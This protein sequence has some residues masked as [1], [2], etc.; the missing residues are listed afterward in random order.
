MGRIVAQLPIWHAI[1]RQLRNPSGLD[2]RL[3]SAAMGIANAQPNRVAIKALRIEPQDTVLE[4]GFGPGYAIK[5]MARE[6]FDGH[7]YGVDQSALMPE[8]AGR[9]NRAAIREGR[10]ALHQARFDCL[11][12]DDACIDK[13]LAVNVIYFWDD[14]P[15]MA[16][17]IRRVL[18]PGG[19]AAVYATDSGKMSRW[20]FAGA[21]THRLYGAQSLP[22]ALANAGFDLHHVFVRKVHIIGSIRGVLTTFRYGDKVSALPS[23]AIARARPAH[24]VYPRPRPPG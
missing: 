21:P 13:L 5:A 2:G 23:N 12:C 16:R 11:P 18:R 4:L 14:L 24:A 17:E 22:E 1:G 8:Q 6:A 15:R 3:T 20:K 7:V 19:R 9:R 10:V